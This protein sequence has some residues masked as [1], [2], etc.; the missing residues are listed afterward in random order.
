MFTVFIIAVL[1]QTVVTF[2]FKNEYMFNKP[3]IKFI[4]LWRLWWQISFFVELYWPGFLNHSREYTAKHSYATIYSEMNWSLIFQ[5][6]DNSV[7]CTSSQICTHL[8]GLLIDCFNIWIFSTLVLKPLFII[9][10]IVFPKIWDPKE[11]KIHWL[12]HCLRYVHIFS[13]TWLPTWCVLVTCENW[14]DFQHAGTE[15]VSA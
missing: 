11:S 5:L 7:L 15:T 13:E 10:L 1:F 3:S 6:L 4:F 9:F 14:N 8:A 2:S 12:S